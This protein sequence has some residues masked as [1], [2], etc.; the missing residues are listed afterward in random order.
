MRGNLELRSIV[1]AAEVIL[2]RTFERAVQLQYV[3][4]FPTGRVKKSVV[5]RCRVKNRDSDLLQTVVVKR[6]GT[7]SKRGA[8]G[9]LKDC[10]S[11]RFLSE[12]LHDE[13][14]SAEFYGVDRKQ[15]ISV[16]EDLGDGDAI[17]DVLENGDR[18]GAESVLL[19]YAQLLGRVHA[20]SA[21]K[22]D[23]Y[24]SILE[25]LGSLGAA[26]TLYT[27]PWSDA[28]RQ[29]IEA[30]EIDPVIGRDKEI[31]E[32]LSVARPSGFQ[33]EIIRTTEAVED[34]CN[35]LLVFSQGDQNGVGGILR[36]NERLR[37]FDFDCGGF[38]HALRE[39][40]PA[41]T[42]WGGMKRVPRSIQEAMGR[43]YREQFIEGCPALRSDVEFARAKVVASAHWHIFHVIVRLPKAL[44]K[45][46][47]RGPS[48]LR[49]QVVA[50]LSGFAE[51]SEETNDMEALGTCARRILSQLKNRW[52][53]SC[54]ELPTF[55]AF[56]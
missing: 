46:H 35:D 38:R 22:A 54:F 37:M 41:R 45:D 3:R 27:D 16:I 21:G 34:P 2:S 49:Q 12:S 1:A 14:F 47:Q 6:I 19:E 30:R 17:E 20:H 13:G 44:E 25:S 23:E 53:K 24:Y 28:R 56:K 15:C 32:R 33:D 50:W 18:D 26:P 55:G 48:T 5:I 40:I 9:F 7:D 52:P 29:T 42:T 10:S 43:A 8:I 31:C 51:I 4:Q 11:Y 36:K 39:G